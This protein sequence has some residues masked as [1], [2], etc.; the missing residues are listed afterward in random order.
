MFKWKDEY[1]VK[2]S[3][4]DE[5]HKKLLSIGEELFDI[6]SDSGNIDYY[7]EIVEILKRLEDYTIYHF[8]FEEELMAKY[9]YDDLERHKEQ[10]AK[11]VNKIKSITDDAV[12]E[13]QKSVTMD[14][15]MF[16][17]DWIEK[18]ILKVDH[19]YKDIVLEK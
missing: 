9:N 18:H 6:V 12:D 10:H 15:I 8:Q 17:A 2:I 13:S 19:R 1:S 4:I 3:S 5:Q 14:M 16:I 11:F 7:D